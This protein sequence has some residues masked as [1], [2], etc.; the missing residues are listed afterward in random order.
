MNAE[1]MA[2]SAVPPL[3]VDITRQSEAWDLSAEEGV[4]RAVQ[5]AFLETGKGLKGAHELSVLLA[6]NEF[7]HTLNRKY[8]GKD[9][10]TNVLSFPQADLLVTD[11]AGLMGEVALGDIVLAIE[12]VTEEAVNQQKTFEDHLTHLVVH[13]VLHLLGYDHEDDA[14]A[15]EM[16]AL[17]VEILKGM[18]ITNPY[19]T[20]QKET[21][22]AR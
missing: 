11:E 10:P 6:D 21:S 12:T 13:G 14:D 1:T 16:E 19:A 5:T 18:K 3:N 4:L 22:S 8:R 2:S 9:K 15:E 20:A 7:I 17:E